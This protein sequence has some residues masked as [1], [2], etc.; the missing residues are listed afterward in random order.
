MKR[1][2]WAVLCVGL[3]GSWLLQESVAA[4]IFGT[5]DSYAA[6]VFCDT[7]HL[8]RIEIDHYRSYKDAANATGGV[9]IDGQFAGA[10][11]GWKLHWIQAIVFDDDPL[12]WRGDG[13]TIVDAPYVDTPPGGYVGPNNAFDYLVYYDEGEFPTFFD[14][15]STS[16]FTIKDNEIV[17][18]EFETWLVCVCEENLGANDTLASDD[19]YVV[20]PLLGF[21]W[22]YT[23]SYLSDLPPPGDTLNDFD[24]TKSTF[25]WL[26]APTQGWIDSLDKVYGAEDLDR[27]NVTLVDCEL[28]PEPST[29]VLAALG[30]VSLVTFRRRT[31]H[32]SSSG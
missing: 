8:G 25:N 13:I 1:C 31:R 6:N 5:D 17:S 29:F 12:A 27:Y 15:P 16:L 24:I 22:G 23:G 4:P 18:V 11:D 32:P 19:S 26:S 7:R 2:V 14:Q 21:T 10:A 3:L 9:Q 28:C 30:L 20:A